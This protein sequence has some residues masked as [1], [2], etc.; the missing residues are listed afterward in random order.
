[1]LDRIVFSWVKLSTK[2][3]EPKTEGSGPT[4][5]RSKTKKPKT[6]PKR[7]SDQEVEELPLVSTRH[8]KRKCWKCDEIYDAVPG[9]MKAHQAVCP[10]NELEAGLRRLGRM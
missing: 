9:A 8:S 2:E 10:A 1:M 6:Q 5:V 4:K 7:K 3:E